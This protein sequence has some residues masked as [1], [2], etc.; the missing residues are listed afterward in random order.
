MSRKDRSIMSWNRMKWFLAG[1]RPAWYHYVSAFRDNLNIWAVW[2]PGDLSIEV[3]D[4]G[5]VEDGLFRKRGSL[6]SVI[7]FEDK[8]VRKRPNAANLQLGG[9]TNKHL[10]AHGKVAA[11]ALASASANLNIGASQGVFLRAT[12]LT[13]SSLLSPTSIERRLSDAVR[14]KK[15]SWEPDWLLVHEVISAAS[16]IAI[17]T[18]SQ[19]VSLQV[20]GSVEALDNMNIGKA[21]GDGK[22]AISGDTA[23][24]ILGK[25]GPLGLGLMNVEVPLLDD[26]WNRFTSGGASPVQL[27]IVSPQSVTWADTPSK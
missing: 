4:F 25:A 6:R 7:G 13:K 16:F 17:S 3:G 21:T 9:F 20:H 19:N 8:D 12:D 18:Q 14:A 15:L 11:E 27:R 5:P 22:L 26:E 1:K 23:M 24:T 2:I 10:E